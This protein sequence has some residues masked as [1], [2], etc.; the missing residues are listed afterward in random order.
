M[1]LRDEVICR[2]R[3]LVRHLGARRRKPLTL[4]AK[5][6]CVGACSMGAVLA[7]PYKQQVVTRAPRPHSEAHR[8]TLHL[9]HAHHPPSSR[10][11]PPRVRPITTR[12]ASDTSSGSTA[13]LVHLV[14]GRNPVE[15]VAKLLNLGKQVPR[16]NRCIG[17]VR[18]G[19]GL[20]DGVVPRAKPLQDRRVGDHAVLAELLERR[21]SIN[22][23]NHGHAADLTE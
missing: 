15:V 19:P 5:S 13:V 23:T 18:I 14:A 21:F 2:N 16:W 7:H 11:T 3:Q 17:R 12:I 4:R 9:T 10:R 8:V 20:L 1:K 22:V 6:L